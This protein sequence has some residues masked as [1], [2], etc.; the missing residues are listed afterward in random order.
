MSTE[1]EFGMMW[2]QAKECWKPLEAGRGKE[3]ISPQSFWKE[4]ALPPP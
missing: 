1:A 2:P 4:P 3:Q